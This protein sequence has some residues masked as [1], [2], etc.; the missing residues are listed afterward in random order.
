MLFRIRSNSSL[1]DVTVAMVRQLRAELDWCQKFY[2]ATVTVF[3]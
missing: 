1:Y 2:V 3:I